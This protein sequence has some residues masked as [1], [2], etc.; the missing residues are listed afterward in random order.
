MF[1]LDLQQD[2]ILL[3]QKLRGAGGHLVRH[4]KWYEVLVQ[5]IGDYLCIFQMEDIKQ[6]PWQSDQT[7]P[8]AVSL[9]IL[10]RNILM[11]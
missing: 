9:Q 11:Y 7:A 4:L 1:T 8:A 6:L 2:C 10:K 5:V 3:Q